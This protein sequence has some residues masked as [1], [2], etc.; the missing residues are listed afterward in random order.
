MLQ[1]AAKKL[2]PQQ[3]AVAQPK[4]AQIAHHLHQPPLEE[5]P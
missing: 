2:D 1:V 4:K 5:N 3:V